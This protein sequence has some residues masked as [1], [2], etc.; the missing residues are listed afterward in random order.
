MSFLS[1][2]FTCD[3]YLKEIQIGAALEKESSA[4]YKEAKNTL[5]LSC[6]T[7]LRQYELDQV[8]G[9]PKLI[10]LISAFF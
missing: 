8:P 1:S 7:S 6:A 10:T 3:K 2:N 5:G 9:V 4:L